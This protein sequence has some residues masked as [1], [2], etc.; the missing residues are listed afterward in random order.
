[1][2]LHF[3]QALIR[4]FITITLHD[5]E[6]EFEWREARAEKSGLLSPAF[7][8][9]LGGILGIIDLKITYFIS[10]SDSLFSIILISGFTEPARV[11]AQVFSF[12]QTF[13]H[14]LSRLGHPVLAWIFVGMVVMYTFEHIPFE[15]YQP[16]IQLLDSNFY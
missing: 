1:V 16:Y 15:I 3:N 4:H 10:L 8:C 13:G 5:Q 9:L 2:E 14:C 6:S 12:N 11:S 7:S